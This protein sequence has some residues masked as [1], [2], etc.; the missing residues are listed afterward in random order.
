MYVYM[1][2]L[3]SFLMQEY[4]HTGAF[5]TAGHHLLAQWWRQLRLYLY[6]LLAFKHESIAW[7]KTSNAEDGRELLGTVRQSLAALKNIKEI[8]P[9]NACNCMI[10]SQRALLQLNIFTDANG[11]YFSY[12]EDC[13]CPMPTESP[14]SNLYLLAITRALFSLVPFLENTCTV[15]SLHYLH[16]KHWCLKIKPIPN[17]PE[18]GGECPAL[19]RIKPSNKGNKNLTG[20]KRSQP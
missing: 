19:C 8:L 7:R 13:H 20:S 5:S 9:N 16:K 17:V 12:F 6:D 10:L 3:R 11:S 15:R 4:L 18:Q 14:L 1:Y 2:V